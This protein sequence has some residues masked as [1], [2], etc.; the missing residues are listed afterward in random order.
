M[1]TSERAYHQIRWDP[2]LS[3]ERF[4]VGVDVHAAHPKRVPLPDFVPGGDLPWHRVLFIELDGT[5]V[6]DR[7]TGTDL[8]D[9]LAQRGLARPRPLIG[10]SWRARDPVVWREAWVP[11][12]GRS[13]GPEPAG[14]VLRLVTWNVL[15]DRFEP[16]ALRS[17][18]RWPRLLDRLLDEAPDL[19]AL[20]EVDPAFHALVLADPRVRASYWVS[21]GPD[22]ADLVPFDLLWLGRVAVHQVAHWPLGPHKNLLACAVEGAVAIN[23]HL[24]SDHSAK[25]TPIRAAQLD[26]L[27]S[28]VAAV[29]GPLVVCGDLNEHDE[30]PEALEALDDA[31]LSAHPRSEPTFDPSA[32]PLAALASLS[33]R[34]ARLD[35]VLLRDLHVHGIQ[36]LGTEPEGDLWLSDH[37]GLSASV[38]ARP[39]EHVHPGAPTPRS[40]L[41]WLPDDTR[42]IQAVRAEHD[43]SFVRWPPH[44]NVLWGFVDEHALEAASGPLEH[45]LASALPFS[46]QLDTLQTFVHRRTASHGLA[47]R[48][49]EPWIAL[50]ARVRRAF[51]RCGR[52]DLQPHLTFART[53][54]GGEP[55]DAPELGGEVHTLA[56]LTRRADEPFAVRAW[57][58]LGGPVQ[59]V[60]EP[61]W[62]PGSPAGSGVRESSSHSSLLAALPGAV[63]VGSHQLG[64]AIAGSDLDLV[65]PDTPPERVL[66]LLEPHVDAVV[67]VVKAGMAGF[68]AWR[69]SLVIDALP[70]NGDPRAVSAIADGQAILAAVA[71]RE[72][73]FRDLLITVKAWARA[74]SLDDAAWG[75]LEGLAWAV[76]AARVVRDAPGPD[77]LVARFFTTW[78]AHDWSRAVSLAADPDVPGFAILTPS[79]PVRNIAER[80]QVGRLE[81]ALLAAWD[82]L[83]RGASRDDL[84]RP[85]PFHRRFAT[86][87]RIHC[88]SREAQG[89]A[90]GRGRALLDLT[91]GVP[92]PGNPHVLGLPSAEPAVLEAAERWAEPLAGVTVEGVDTNTV[93]TPGARST[94]EP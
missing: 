30:R 27:R 36:R 8:L 77:G 43:P 68:R 81:D 93:P 46:T 2:R 63:V 87:L 9:S 42:A 71:G 21:H 62:P 65:W 18:D 85:F 76:L 31:W 15:W 88:D 82:A 45:A 6:W 47:P 24:T 86:A 7:A 22:H 60:P 79:A 33:G 3:P 50:H 69:A 92:C 61:V 32:N 53:P 64:T 56:V 89:L 78:A 67:P 74:Q 13:D 19:V 12:E 75:G 66:E 41:A 23:V 5:R 4:V 25:A 84:W 94:I 14:D 38:S 26:T 59:H 35:R 37:C 16:E 10:G 55:P 1:R 72:A 39:P 48:E 83:E 58:V 11:V 17:A 49:P 90:R 20:Q 54:P 44:V 34:A 80:V 40:A 29:H 73:A 52:P 91:G 51:P 70:A 57:G 28:V